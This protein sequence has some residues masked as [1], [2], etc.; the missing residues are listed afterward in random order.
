VCVCVCARA[1]CCAH[2]IVLCTAYWINAQIIDHKIIVFVVNSTIQIVS[3]AASVY[4]QLNDIGQLRFLALQDL[5]I[6]SSRECKTNPCQSAFTQT[7]SLLLTLPVAHTPTPYLLTSTKLEL[8]I[9]RLRPNDTVRSKLERSRADALHNNRPCVSFRVMLY[10]PVSLIVP[11]TCI[12]L[13]GR[14]LSPFGATK[15]QQ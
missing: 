14:D 10:P 7:P 5:S 8:C 2:N 6:T 9:I 1:Y 13:V 15:I 3:G 11:H 4:W 12:P